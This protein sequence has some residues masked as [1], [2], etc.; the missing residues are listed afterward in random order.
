YRREK[1]LSQKELISAGSQSCRILFFG[2]AGGS[3]HPNELKIRQTI[4]QV[5][6]DRQN[7]HS[8]RHDD[9][10][11]RLLKWNFMPV[12]P[13][14]RIKPGEKLVHVIRIT[15]IFSC[16]ICTRVPYACLC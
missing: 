4:I 16:F 2:E 15:Q 1:S 3:M 11:H 5:F 10:M 12:L 13:V 8:L 6:P 7:L 14:Y 9:I